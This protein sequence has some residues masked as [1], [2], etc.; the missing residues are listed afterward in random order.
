MTD[1]Q[2]FQESPP[3]QALARR[4]RPIS[5]ETPPML[6]FQPMPSGDCQTARYRAKPKFAFPIPLRAVLLDL[7]GTLLDTAGDI[8]EAAKSYA[9]FVGFCSPRSRV[10][11]NLRRQRHR[12]P[13][14]EDLERMP[15]V[16]S[17]PQL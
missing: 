12:Q 9:F 3:N 7:D 10:D 15:W 4:L 13:S 8:A 2:E 5:P 11:Q 14:F 16:K 17:A 1:V 6:E